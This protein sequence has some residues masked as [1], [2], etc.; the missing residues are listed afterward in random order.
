[1]ECFRAKWIVSR[2]FVNRKLRYTDVYDDS[3]SKTHLAVNEIYPNITV[4]KL[5]CIGHVQKQV[6]GRLRKLK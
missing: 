2:S 5:E 4:R 6:G 3:G 1:M